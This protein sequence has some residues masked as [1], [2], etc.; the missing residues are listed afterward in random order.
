MGFLFPFGRPSLYRIK[1]QFGGGEE[2]GLKVTGRTGEGLK[3]AP[4]VIKPLEL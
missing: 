3:R 1:A 4:L 2:G